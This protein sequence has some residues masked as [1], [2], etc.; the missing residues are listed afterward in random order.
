MSYHA[1]YRRYRPTRFKDIIG[2]EH[3]TSILKN[4]IRT[5]HIA[6]AYLFSG[7]RGTG[8]TT[9]ARIL[10]RAVNCISP[11]DGECCGEC[12]ACKINAAD[13]IDIIEMDA[14]S[15]SKVDEMRALL[16][17]AELTPI[18]LR[19]KV[20]IIDEAHMLSKSANNALLKTL[21]EP[22]EHVIF[23]LATTEPQALPAT[24]L[25]RCQ[26]FDFKRLSASAMAEYL[27][28]VLTDAGA[29]IDDDGV[30]CI[31]RAADGGMRDCLS[32]ADQCL[33]YCGNNITYSDVLTVLGSMDSGF[34]FNFADRVIESD[35][36]GALEM[37]NEVV[38]GGRDI[39]VFIQ[40]LASHFRALLLA[41]VCGNCGD[42]LD[43]TSDDMQQ[44]I[45]QAARAARTRIERALSELMDLQQNLK[46]VMMPRILLE[47][48]IVKICRP[49]E[50]QG[51]IELKDRIETIETMLRSG[52]IAISGAGDAVQAETSSEGSGTPNK[53]HEVSERK[54]DEPEAVGQEGDR[55]MDEIPQPSV[56][57]DN[58]YNAFMAALMKSDIMLGI[59]LQMAKA[60]W[61]SDECL[62]ICFDK[63]KRS[64]YNYV[65]SSE[66]RL[67]LRQA[68]ALSIEPFSVEVVQR[69]AG[70]S[71]AA[72]TPNQLFGIEIT[73]E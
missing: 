14:A 43:C 46:W 63:S 7:S 44:Y 72:N 11:E 58:L 73:E 69:D 3:I 15:N 36:S 62:Y 6:H 8:K 45:G 27:R 55:G 65:S 39:G 34:L 19:Y 52:R 57:A 61:C 1:L 38:S 35:T 5:G 41:K 23:I 70:N 10:A 33:S 47:S 20:Y 59:Q 53:P 30:L 4:Q 60:H 29:A 42:I 18:Y 71:D 31:A 16:D 21:E 48:A 9:T 37:I 26:R 2:Q 32:I 51:M 66:N 67:K 49:D 28:K 24:I 12:G 25:S 13:C 68:A 56:Q 54:Q 50:Q 17:K 40:D 22:P 64:N